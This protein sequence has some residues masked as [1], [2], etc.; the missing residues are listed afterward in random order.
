MALGSQLCYNPHPVRPFWL[1][2]SIPM[3]QSSSNSL[4]PRARR[5]R[6]AI[7]AA[8]A[9]V[10]LLLLAAIV[11]AV[12]LF[13]P[14]RSAAAVIYLSP[15]AAPVDEE[16]RISV[17]GVGWRDDQQIAV[18]LAAG[19]DEYCSADVA[20]AVA[21]V[22]ADGTFQTAIAAGARLQ[23]GFTTILAQGIDSGHVAT[24]AFRVLTARGETIGDLA[25]VGDEPAADEPLSADDGAI[26]LPLIVSGE[27]G[28]QG[29][30][31]D[32][33][34]LAGEPVLQ[35]VDQSLSMNWGE[36][37]P[38]PEL[39]ANGFSARWTTRATFAGRPYL[40]TVSADGGVRLYVDGQIVIDR[41]FAEPGSVTGSVDLQAGEHVVVVEYFSEGGPAFISAGWS[42]NDAFADWRGEYFANP[43]LAGEPE[44]VRND[45]EV[46]FN[47]GRSGPAP[48]VLPADSFSA[49]W[50]RT[51]EFAEGVYRWTLM[52][53]D[54]A[55]VMVD[56]RVVLD[57]W[58]GMAGQ[59]VAEDVSVAAGP[60]EIVVELR[61]AEGAGGI[62]F[63]WDA[64]PND[65]SAPATQT[66]D[67]LV[68]QSTETPELP[69][70]TPE[71]TALETATETATAEPGATPTP[72]P[73]DNPAFTA[74][75]T[76]T[77]APGQTPSPTPTNGAG[78][79]VPSATPTPT[80]TATREALVH[81]VDVNPFPAVPGDE[82][83]LT[84]GNWTPGIRVTVAIVEAGEPFSQSVEVPGTATTTPI[85]AAQGFTIQFIFPTDSRWQLGSDVWIIIHNADW[86]EWGR[87]ELELREE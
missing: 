27:G 54:G 78:T 9:L 65:G 42:E 70:A 34:D 20:L 33:P 4:A 76:P 50:T 17:S 25:A 29:D 87:G 39:P 61:N 11:A 46:N 45:Q 57:A 36:E 85:N 56:G 44:L 64:A 55:R 68:H 37:A 43:D 49:R 58:Q 14:N 60:R 23:Q 62:V 30:Y 69:T 16:S 21:D 80:S 3:T 66:P 31:F 71:A 13:R 75:P 41:W 82:I 83:G 22:A 67:P 1:A 48:G 47:W 86:S 28:W 15:A 26:N 24:R 59:T 72:T 38:A 7:L 5:R 53:D 51:Q 12:A 8:L 10:A 77:D 2:N 6:V 74:T 19:A 40:F 18:C 35:R 79:A 73:T 81:F 84:T 32:N 52:A 63:G